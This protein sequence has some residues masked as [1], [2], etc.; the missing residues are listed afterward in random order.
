MTDHTDREHMDQVDDYLGREVWIYDSA[1]GESRKGEVV[2][3][4]THEDGA[5]LTVALGDTTVY[6][7]PPEAVTKH[8]PI[9]SLAKDLRPGMMMRL[10]ATERW[11]FV[12]RV[13]IHRAEQTDYTRAGAYET[14]H[15]EVHVWSDNRR[16]PYTTAIDAMVEVLPPVG[17]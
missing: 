2:Q 11:V 3:V 17:S 4:Q 10:Y 9:K 7:A 13:R 15:S 12:D 8:K 1:E 14:G 16:H 6:N 5:R